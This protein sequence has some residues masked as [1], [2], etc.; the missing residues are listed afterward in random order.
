MPK[1]ARFSIFDPKLKVRCVLK[2]SW[3]GNFSHNVSIY[4]LALLDAKKTQKLPKIAIKVPKEVKILARIKS[5]GC[6]EIV[7]AREFQPQTQIFHFGTL[8]CQKWPKTAK[9]S[10]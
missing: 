3:Q 8:R 7:M 10:H 5:K 1:Q 2:L 6:F 4:I 9:N